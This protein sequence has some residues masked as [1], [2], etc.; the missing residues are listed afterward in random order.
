MALAMRGVW[1]SVHT[2][3]SRVVDSQPCSSCP[4]SVL[5]LVCV[6]FGFESEIAFAYLLIV[7]EGLDEAVVMIETS[8][9]AI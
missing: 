1:R 4:V 3:Q 2:W 6:V 7:I 8:G 5:I 9:R